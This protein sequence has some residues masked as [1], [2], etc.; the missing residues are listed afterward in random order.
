MK[1]TK[2]RTIVPGSTLG[3][4]GGGQLGRMFAHSAQR[5]GY[6]V[7]VFTDEADSPAAQVANETVLGDYLDPLAVRLFAEKVDV[8]TLEFENIELEAVTR[9]AEVTL[10]RPGVGVLSVAQHRI[11][12][13]STLADFGFQV[14]PFREIRCIQDVTPAAT[15]IGWPLVLKTTNW[16]YDG[17][18]QRRVSDQIEANDAIELLGPEPLIA[19]KWI[20]YVAEVSV[21]VAR[22]PSGE[23][24][25]YP[26]FTNSHSNHVLDITT[27]P[28]F[29]ELQQIAPKAE[30]IAIAVAE[31]LQL[32]GILCVEFFVGYDGELMINEI[33]PRPHNSGHLTIEACRT[34]QF[35]QQVRAVC[36]LP[37][38]DTS[39]IQPA[40]MANLLGDVW[41]N[42]GTDEPRFER[43]LQEPLTYLHLYGKQ[44]ARQG[45]KMG[46]ITKLSTS[47]SL[48]STQVCAIREAIRST[49]QTLF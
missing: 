7:V 20:R 6:R 1:S 41:G 45:R 35:E 43:A 11:K 31:S 33:A 19:E 39:L 28:A 10:V 8:I 25:V 32:E 37:L 18:G 49:E 42:R 9:A 40:A 27:C 17:K 29:P 14:T 36:N 34:S 21:I 2:N 24:A 22:S 13:K 30:S 47:A 16:G 4:F 26:M 48:A 5:L 15:E 12:E 23:T 3:V 44:T 38:G 46:H